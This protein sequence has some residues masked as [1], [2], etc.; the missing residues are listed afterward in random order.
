VLSQTS[1]VSNVAP[2]TLDQP[3]AGEAEG[4]QDSDNGGYPSPGFPM[5]CCPPEGWGP[6][7][8]LWAGDFSPLPQPTADGT[9]SD[10]QPADDSGV[11]SDIPSSNTSGTD[12]A[13]LPSDDANSVV[14][15]PVNQQQ[16]G[17]DDPT[18]VDTQPVSDSSPVTGDNVTDPTSAENCPPITDAS[19]G[20]ALDAVPFEPQSEDAADEAKPVDA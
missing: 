4:S 9:G 19:G 17:R 11:S 6:Y 14:V 8:D 3:T 20:T 18:V 7:I 12:N 5:N 15:E 2:I 16:V 13:S 1:S 10:G